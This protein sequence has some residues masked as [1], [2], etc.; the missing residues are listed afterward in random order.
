MVYEFHQY[1]VA[2]FHP[3]DNFPSAIDDVDATDYIVVDYSSAAAHVS[4]LASISAQQG[5]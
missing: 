5:L 2:L 4:L 3:I 1:C